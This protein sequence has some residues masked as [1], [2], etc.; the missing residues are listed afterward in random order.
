MLSEEWRN[1]ITHALSFVLS[2]TL[3]TRSFES[4]IFCLIYW[5]QK[6]FLA[7][8]S[9]VPRI[10]F[11]LCEHKK[12][13]NF[14]SRMTTKI[15]FVGATERNSTSPLLSA[16]PRHRDKVLS[17]LGKSSAGR[18]ADFLHDLYTWILN[19]CE[20]PPFNFVE[21]FSFRQLGCRI[22]LRHS[23]ILIVTLTA[24]IKFHIKF[25]INLCQ[26]VSHSLPFSAQIS[27]CVCVSFI[28]SLTA[29]YFMHIIWHTHI[30][31]IFMA[32]TANDFPDHNSARI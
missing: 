14:I 30:Y 27:V 31:D 24:M 23:L 13:H 3:W 18:D 16:T 6:R 11:D 25:M 26:T 1:C 4:W 21:A 8:I 2:F 17:K 15:A 5:K 12:V 19:V 7:R 28:R 20:L 32:Q 9:A 29:D 10:A 22:D